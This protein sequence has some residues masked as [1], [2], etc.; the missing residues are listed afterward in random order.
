VDYDALPIDNRLGSDWDSLAIA[1]STPFVIGNLKSIWVC[2][3]LIGYAKADRPMW[4][5][6][7]RAAETFKQRISLLFVLEGDQGIDARGAAGRNIARE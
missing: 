5:R 4:L 2:T 6:I 3:A 7:S 1:G